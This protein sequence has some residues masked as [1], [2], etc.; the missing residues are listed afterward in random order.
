M[1]LI[2]RCNICFIFTYTFDV[3]SFVCMQTRFMANVQTVHTIVHTVTYVT[4][5]IKIAKRRRRITTLT[6]TA[7]ISYTS[8]YAYV[9][10]KQKRER[11]LV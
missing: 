7:S 6:T 8:S 5:S 11:E 9:F 1:Y 2:S 3:I 10:F 4:F